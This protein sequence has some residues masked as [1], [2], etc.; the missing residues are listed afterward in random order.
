MQKLRFYTYERA[1]RILRAKA[2]ILPDESFF[3][4]TIQVVVLAGALSQDGKCITTDKETSFT[5]LGP[6]LCTEIMAT[7]V[8]IL[9]HRLQLWIIWNCSVYDYECK[10]CCLYWG[11]NLQDDNGNQY[12]LKWY[13]TAHTNLLHKTVDV[14]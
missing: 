10:T 7:D 11:N 2:V 6:F 13:Y 8:M 14:R 3:Q 5:Q 9:H 12:Y 4:C 1:H